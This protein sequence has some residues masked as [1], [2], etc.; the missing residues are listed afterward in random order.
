MISR[1]NIAAKTAS[2][3]PDDVAVKTFFLGP[4]AENGSWLLEMIDEMFKDWFRWRAECFPADGRAI[5]LEDQAAPAFLMKQQRFKE[6]TKLLTKRFEKEVP[7]FSPRY[8]GH[9][10][11]ETSLPALLGHIVSLLHNPNNVSVEASRIGTKIE[12]E[13]IEFLAAMIGCRPHTAKGH[14]TSGGSVANYESI[15]RARF[16]LIQNLALGAYLQ[17]A[18]NENRSHFEWA[19]LSKGEYKKL[20]Q[21]FEPTTKQLDKYHPYKTST[22]ELCRNLDRVFGE[23][24][25]DPVAL[26]P[27]SKHYSWEKGLK[28]IGGS[29]STLWP[30]ELD[31]L[32]HLCLNDLA[33]KIQKA[34][35]ENR[36]ILM[37]VSVAGTTELGEIDPVDKV[38]DLLDQ[39]NVTRGISIWHH[40]DGAYG[41]FLCS[42]L[43]SAEPGESK[44]SKSACDSLGAL[45]R[46]NS[47][48]L[49][50]H[51]LGYVP[52]SAG[53]FICSDPE[54]YPTD[55]VDAPYVSFSKDQDCGLFTIEGSRSAAGATATWMTA[56]C[57][58]LHASGYGQIIGRTI[59]NRIRLEQALRSANKDIRIAPGMESNICC[60]CVAKPGEALS[61]TNQRSLQIYSDFSPSQENPEFYLSKTHLRFDKYQKY[62]SSYVRDWNPII[63]TDELIVLRSVLM[64]VFLQTRETEINF[65]DSFV[66]EICS[67][68]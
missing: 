13:A 18:T 52:F 68:S 61:Q 11:S 28:F 42:L 27:Q 16:R 22:K 8:I 59:E 20:F 15:R 60:F 9:M 50:P 48:T 4:Q 35:V 43:Q 39:L 6:F 54:D 26:I 41:G 25:N 66:D 23:K 34:E 56:Q 40:V 57:I 24:W 36:P 44:L 37:I 63:D 64:N 10:F 14:F 49:D 30:I 2:C 47:I 29:S 45:Y 3:K 55:I 1:S 7:K 58:G 31:E 12:L 62:L 17:E 33:T 51:K 5:S 21:C 53:A 38:Q 19:H 46:A 65:I 67:R 32:G